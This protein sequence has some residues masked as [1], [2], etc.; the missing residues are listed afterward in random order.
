[1]INKTTLSKYCRT[2]ATRPSVYPKVVINTTHPAAP[3]MLN[4]RNRKYG[5]SA[6]PATNA[7]K[8]RMIGTNRA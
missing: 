7:A 4:G 5:I 2:K 6:T 1:M 3:Q 8:V